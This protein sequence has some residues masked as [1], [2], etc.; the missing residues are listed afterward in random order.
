MICKYKKFLE[1]SDIPM[2]MKTLLV[3]I[4][5]IFEESVID[6][7]IESQ[8][9]DITIYVPLNNKTDFRTIMNLFLA[10][11]SVVK[12]LP[13]YSIEQDLWIDQQEKPL[14]SFYLT[15]LV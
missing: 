11:D 8:G 4:E 7:D 5:G 9:F 12:L 13:G 1:K 14:Y 2:D 3:D 15:Y 6:V 10:M